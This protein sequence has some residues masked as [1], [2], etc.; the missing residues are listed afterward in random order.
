MYFFFQKIRTESSLF[1]IFL[2]KHSS[3]VDRHRVDADPDLDRDL[4]PILKL[5]LR[6]M[7]QILKKISFG[8]GSVNLYYGTGSP[9]GSLVKDPDTDPG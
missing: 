4:D 5:D 6:T 7:L 1:V 2:K 9:Q 8:S 3:V